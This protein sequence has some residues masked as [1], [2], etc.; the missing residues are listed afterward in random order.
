M[1]IWDADQPLSTD[2]PGIFPSKCQANWDVLFD[3]LGAD[4]LFRTTTGVTD[5]GY[6]KI[7]H[8]VNQSDP[9]YINGTGM[10]YAK[11]QVITLDSVDQTAPQLFHRTSD[12]TT[13][14]E[15]PITCVPIRAFVNFDGTVG[16]KG[17]GD[18]QTIRS[19][20]NVDS[21]KRI[22]TRSGNYEITFTPGTIPSAAYAVL[23]T[24]Q[25]SGVTSNGKACYIAIND[26]AYTTAVTTSVLQI[27]CSSDGTNSHDVF[28]GN[29]IIVGG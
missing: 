9:T 20:F 13:T 2:S 6:H 29:V 22:G 27:T 17:S 3:N 14:R 28:M 26:V 21:V 10:T 1:A 18:T 25:R 12:G 23:G 8:W 16:L 15:N 5:Q 7:I 4:H 11:D 19:S 24:A